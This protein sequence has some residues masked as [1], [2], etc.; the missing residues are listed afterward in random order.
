MFLDFNARKLENDTYTYSYI[1]IFCTELQTKCAVPIKNLCS[2]KS[3]EHRVLTLSC[4]F[5]YFTYAKKI[6][7]TPF[8]F[9]YSSYARN[10]NRTKQRVHLIIS[11]S[12]AINLEMQLYVSR[13][14]S[15]VLNLKKNYYP[16][17]QLSEKF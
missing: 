12:T 6:S 15:M 16:M 14:Y 9:K 11:V 3:I 7:G 17:I 13:P 10:D 1:T 4:N 2:F 5:K 8:L